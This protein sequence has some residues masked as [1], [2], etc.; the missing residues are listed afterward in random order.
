LE[1]LARIAAKLGLRARAARGAAPIP[2]LW[3]FTD[4]LRTPD[5][6]AGARLLPAGSAV[7]YRA[8]GAADARLIACRLRRIARERGLRLLIGA[9]SRL[10]AEVGADGVHLPQRLMPLAPRLARAHPG[11]LISA[12]AHDAAAIRRGSVLGLHALVVSAVFPSRSPS[13][14]RA[15]GPVRFAALIKGAT[16]PMIALGGVTNKN[17][18]RLLST[19]AAGIAAVE[20]LAGTPRT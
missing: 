3:F 14:G 20:G 7:V 9:D 17:A 11:W 1:A 18:P 13:A 19:D 5:P 8:F 16:V 10:A 6:E 12:A 15:M 2:H 4:P